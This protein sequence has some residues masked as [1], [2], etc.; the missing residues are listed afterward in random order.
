MK[1][2]LFASFASTCLLSA[3]VFGQFTIEQL[4]EVRR[5]AAGRKEAQSAI[6][7][8][9]KRLTELGELIE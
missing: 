1:K 8:M 4:Q 6:Q 7:K 3:P 5:T 2:L 9:A